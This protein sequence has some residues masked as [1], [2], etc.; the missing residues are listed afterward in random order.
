MVQERVDIMA[1]DKNSAIKLEVCRDNA[2]GK[3]MI[4][5]H[6][7]KDASNV[8]IDKN[9]Y[10]WMPT[11]EEKNLI[12][13]AFSFL[14]LGATSIKS[15]KLKDTPKLEETTIE[16]KQPLA[17][18]EKEKEVTPEPSAMPFE[19]E[20]EDPIFE[21][22]DEILKNDEPA[23][24]EI[25]PEEIVEKKL[26]EKKELE[27]DRNNMDVKVEVKKD[28]PPAD[29][30]NNTTENTDNSEEEKILVE[31]DSDAIEAAIKK[32]SDTGEDNSIVEADEKTI[33][34]KVLNQ[35]KKG[36][37]GRLK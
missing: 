19:K 26:E 10:V 5:A 9:E 34:D 21:K 27:P 28:I 16:E 31:A 23:V 29:F 25:T 3:L 32:H 22:T 13:E 6:F 14:P 20:I 24:F 7:N 37:W 33:I 35:K 2:T 30:E 12:D 11:I 36:K 17:E 15:D 8:I 1:N 18:L 4:M